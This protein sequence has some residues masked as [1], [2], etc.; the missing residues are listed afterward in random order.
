MRSLMSHRRIH[1]PIKQWRGAECVSTHRCFAWKCSGVHMMTAIFKIHRAVHHHVHVPGLQTWGYLRQFSSSLLSEQSSSSSH[2]H[3]VGMHRPFLHWNCPVS[4]S[5]SV[6]VPVSSETSW[7]YTFLVHLL[8]V[9][10][11]CRQQSHILQV[12]IGI[13]RKVQELNQ[14][15]S[16]LHDCLHGSFFVRQHS[17]YFCCFLTFRGMDVIYLRLFCL[18]VKRRLLQYIISLQHKVLNR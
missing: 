2:L 1:N 11:I 3:R 8:I 18:N 12:I 14:E 13:Y 5:D 16:Q 9:M 15:Q 17:G 10:W 7:Q 4:H 6:W